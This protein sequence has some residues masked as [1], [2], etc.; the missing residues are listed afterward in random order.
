MKAGMNYLRQ[1]RTSEEKLGSFLAFS[2]L[3]WKTSVQIQPSIIIR[4]D[5]LVF[6]IIFCG[7]KNEYLKP[8]LLSLKQEIIT[9]AVSF[10]QQRRKVLEE[11]I[12]QAQVPR[13]NRNCVVS[14]I[15]SL[16]FEYGSILDIVAGTQDTLCSNNVNYS[17]TGDLKRQQRDRTQPHK[18]KEHPNPNTRTTCSHRVPN[19]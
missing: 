19:C 10:K 5:S 11:V 9:V 13:L 17:S 2:V 1:V 7:K 16:I 8:T 14:Y 18:Q 6:Q 15:H 3:H 12:A 4:L